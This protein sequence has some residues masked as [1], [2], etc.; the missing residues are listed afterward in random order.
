MPPGTDPHS[1]CTSKKAS[2][3]AGECGS[4]AVEVGLGLDAGRANRHTR[5]ASGCGGSTRSSASAQAPKSSTP[6]V[7]PRCAAP[8]RGCCRSAASCSPA[9]PQCCRAWGRTPRPQPGPPA[10]QSGGKEGGQ[11]GVSGAA[12]HVGS[13]SAAA[14]CWVLASPLPP[15]RLSCSGHAPAA[16]PPPHHPR[17]ATAAIHA[18]APPPR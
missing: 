6:T 9:P 11:R 17:P 15:L 14:A 18:P 10:A 4:G 2:T 13:A 16:T 8:R 1:S 7:P 5:G 12:L 3:C